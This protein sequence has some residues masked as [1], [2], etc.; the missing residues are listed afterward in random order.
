M[1]VIHSLVISTTVTVRRLALTKATNIIALEKTPYGA[2]VNNNFVNGWLLYY[3]TVTLIKTCI[4]KKASSILI[5]I[6]GIL[7][8]ISGLSKLVNVLSFQNLIAQYGFPSLHF[9]APFIVIAEI[10]LGCTLLLHIKTRLVA[11]LSLIMLVFFTAAYTYGNVFHGITDCGCFGN[12]IKTESTT[13]VYIRNLLLISASFYVVINTEPENYN[14]IPS[15][16]KS[17]L[18]TVLLPSVF[19]SG[20]TSMVLPHKKQ[21]NSYQNK[22]LYETPLKDYA[23]PTKKKELLFFMSFSCPHCINSVE[24]FKSYKETRTVDTALCYVLTNKENQHDDSLRK[25]FINHF[26]DICISEIDSNFDFISAYPTA[27][28]IE[29]DTIRQVVVGELPSPFVLLPQ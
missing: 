6:I 4:M 10:T 24:N 16:K 15:W 29:N 22:P 25:S 17:I 7:F 18:L 12:F 19:I 20:M 11:L 5:Y 8:L 21:E 28:Y 13:I 14:D 27:F 26:P 3:L 23:I 2:A 1:L 9:L